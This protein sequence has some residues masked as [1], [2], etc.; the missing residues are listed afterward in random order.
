[1]NI[2]IDV[3]GVLTDLSG[4]ILENGNKFFK[5]KRSVINEN[6]YKLMDMFDCSKEEEDKFWFKYVYK[7][8]LKA[9]CEKDASDVIKKLRKNGHKIYI[10]TSRLYTKE[11]SIKGELFRKMLEYWLKKNNIEY[12]KI[13]YCNDDKVVNDK[14]YVCKKLNINIMIE[15]SIDN[16]VAISKTCRVM[17]RN[18]P[19]NF[20]YNQVTRVS[21]FKDIYYK[22]EER[23]K[24]K[25]YEDKF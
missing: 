1:M 24:C 25:K 14:Y 6:T 3:D 5:G 7:Y 9:K 2:G 18:R 15:D 22:I 16:A 4:F 8:C 23:G 10:I 20:G 13:I 19:Y 11:Q 21:G 12:D 17:L